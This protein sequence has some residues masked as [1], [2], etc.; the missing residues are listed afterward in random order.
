[1]VTGTCY[2]V[3]RPLR[4]RARH[5]G[6]RICSKG[7]VLIADADADA[8][9]ERHLMPALRWQNYR[10]NKFHRIA[11]ATI[12]SMA[13]IVRRPMR[14]TPRPHTRKRCLRDHFPRT[15]FRRRRRSRTP[16]TT[17]IP[18][19]RESRR[20]G[21]GDHSRATD[22]GLTVGGRFR[23]DKAALLR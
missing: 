12:S 8:D 3:A 9:G 18:P 14:F 19:R 1:M 5:P 20:E 6:M 13:R 15:I 7:A 10:G 21:L 11:K 16:R 2:V 4:E 23:S 22:T 17:I